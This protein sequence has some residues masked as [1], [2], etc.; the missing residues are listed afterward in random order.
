MSYK[1]YELTRPITE[2]SR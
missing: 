1:K 2:D